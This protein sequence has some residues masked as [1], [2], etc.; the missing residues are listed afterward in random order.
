[1]HTPGSPELVG[2]QE[3][4][5][6]APRETGSRDGAR[7]AASGIYLACYFSG[8]LIGSAVLGQLFDRFGWTACVCGIG[9]SLVAAAALTIRLKFVIIVSEPPSN[10]P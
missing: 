10:T 8:G 7:G 3:E 2:H 1:V 4:C 9:L 5:E 6:T